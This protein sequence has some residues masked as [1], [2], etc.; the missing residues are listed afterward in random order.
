[1]AKRKIAMNA[2]EQER[3]DDYKTIRVVRNTIRKIRK[4]KKAVPTFLIDQL[5]E[6]KYKVKYPAHYR[7]ALT[8]GEE[9]WKR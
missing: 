1:M 3:Y 4:E 8:L 2:A 9:P 5:N 6:F 7:R